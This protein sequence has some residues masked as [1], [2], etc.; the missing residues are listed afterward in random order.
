MLQLKYIRNAL[1][2]ATV[3]KLEEETNLVNSS[4]QLKKHAQNKL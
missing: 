4:V 3:I 2:I 1:Y